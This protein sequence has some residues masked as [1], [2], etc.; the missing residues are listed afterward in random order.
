MRLFIAKEH[1]L[2]YQTHSIW[3]TIYYV[4]GFVGL[5][6]NNEAEK[7]NHSDKKTQ[8]FD[9]GHLVHVVAENQEKFRLNFIEVNKPTF[10]N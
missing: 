3:F 8:N 9:L 6:C 10:I 2:K 4:L 7:K 1:N 5:T